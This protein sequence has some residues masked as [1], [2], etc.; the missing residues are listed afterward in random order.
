MSCMLDNWT[1]TSNLTRPM[2]LP[3]PNALR[4]GRGCGAKI[5]FTT[6]N[7]LGIQTTV[8]DIVRAD[9]GRSRIFES[10]G[11]DYCFGGRK[12]LAE[13]CQAKGLDPAT[14]VA[15]LAAFDGVPETSSA[16][17]GAMSLGALCDHIEQVHHH[18]LREEL[19]RLDFM[20][21]KVA[22]VHGEH[23]PRLAEIRRVFVAFNA[24]MTAHTAEEE[25]KIFPAI[26]HLESADHAKGEA[27]A[28]KANLD[29]LE[30]EHDQAG[31][32][33]VRLH[34]LTDGYTPPEWACNTFRALYDGLAELEQE[35]HQ[36]VH[37]ENN[38]LFPR[39]LSTA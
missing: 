31:A 20:T 24:A 37:K 2:L 7:S 30:S 10:L 21:R 8:G 23:E 28:L 19:P 12:P 36:H 39:A 18:Y 9:P 6:M 11:I 3:S 35:T 26:R 22:A 17:P 4:S 27:S 5:R 38:I 33:L 32:A 1:L 16:N 15:M 13:V 29:K 34:E 14:V 25:A